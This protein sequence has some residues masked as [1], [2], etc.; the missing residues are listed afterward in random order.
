MNTN[1]FALLFAASLVSPPVDAQLTLPGDF[2]A[3]PAIGGSRYSSIA[4][5]GPGYLVVWEDTRTALE[6]GISA[7]GEPLLGNM[8]DI[9]GVRLDLAGRVLDAAPLVICGLPRN[10]TRPRVAWN[11]SQ[12]LVVFTTER[13]DWYFFHDIVGVRVDS[14]G[15]VLDPTPISIRPEFNSP[16]NYYGANP[17][18]GSD[19]THW[20]VT[21]E[22][23]N[24]ANGRPQARATR[25]AQSGQL[26]DPN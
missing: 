8:M 23:G 22:D 21:W 17:S 24:P 1:L 6:P 7:S 9:Y 3:A 11:G 19:G 26:L 12:W 5:G 18:V 2:V 10:Q 25:I 14:N 20:V 16:A 13:P 4:R 15:T